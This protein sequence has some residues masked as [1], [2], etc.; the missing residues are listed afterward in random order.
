MRN[1][2]YRIL[3]IFVTTLSLLF[4][5]AEHVFPQGKGMS[6]ASTVPP[7]SM[8]SD[9]DARLALARI[10]SYH[11]Q[12][13]DEAVN[14]YHTLLREYPFNTQIIGELSQVY[15]QQKKYRE[16]LELLTELLK[17]KPDDYTIKIA[18][19]KVY[20]VMKNY[21]K[22]LKLFNEIISQKVIDS[23]LYREIGN[24]YLYTGKHT[25]AID[26]YRKALSLNPE[27][28]RIQKQLALALSWN[29][30][31]VEAQK[32]LEILLQQQPEDR[33][34]LI[35][36]ARLY[37]RHNMIH[38]TIDLLM[39]LMQQ[40]PEDPHVLVEVAD[41]EAL[42]GH[43]KKCRIL[44]E[45]ALALN[46][47]DENIRMRYA[48]RMNMWGD[49]YRAERLYKDYL[50]HHPESVEVALK[51][52]RVYASSQRYEESEGLYQKLL[53][54]VKDPVDVLLG[55][56]QLKL[57]E[58]DFIASIG[59]ADSILGKDRLHIE[60]LRVKGESLLYLKEY[61]RAHTVY[62]ALMNQ[63]KSRFSGLIGMGKL[64]RK[65]KK[66]E[67]AAIYFS[68]ALHM[69]PRNVE[70]QFYNTPID[71]VTS[72]RFIFQLMTRE[73]EELQRLYAWA[74][75]Y[76]QY[77]YFKGAILLL[78]KIL[79][80]DPEY[81]PAQILLAETYGAT[82]QYEHAI[83]MYK[84][85][86]AEFLESSKL[87][88]GLARVLGWSKQYRESIDLYKKIYALN[89]H[90]PVPQK[91]MAR[92]AM[93]GK[94]VPL[95][96]ATYEAM[97]TEPV[98]KKLMSELIRIRPSISDEG[99]T[100]YIAELQNKIR[101][102]SLYEGYEEFVNN[103]KQK[104][105]TLS[106]QEKSLLEE[107]K[108]RLL[109]DYRI[110]KSI[111]LEMQAKWHSWNKHF[112]QS[113]PFYEALI[114]FNP[115]NE[116]A[117]FDYAQA[118]CSLGI[119][120]KEGKT[121]EKLLTIDP[122]HNLARIALERQHIRSNPS[123]QSDYSYWMEDGRGELSQITRNRF[124]LTFD[125]PVSCRYR[126]SATGHKWLEYPKFD[127]KTYSAYGFT[128]GFNGVINPFIKSQASWTHK[129][130]SNREIK[131]RDTGFA[132]VWLN[133]KEYVH[134]G[135]GYERKDELYNTFGIRHGIQSD[136]WWVGFHSD[137][138]RTLELHGT[139]RIL[140]YNDSNRGYHHTLAL[141]Y[142]LTDHPRTFKITLSG[143][144]R[145][146]QHEN[147]YLY[148]GPNLVDIIHPYWTPKGYTGTSVTFQWYHD[149]SHLFF[150]G[151]ELR[152]YDIRVSLG[153]DS[154]NNP[155]VKLEGEWHHEF[156][157]R[158]SI[159]LKGMVHSSPKWDAQGIW[160]QL[161]YR[162]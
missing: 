55:L 63:D 40:H 64:L 132:S 87:L 75:L 11:T 83:N 97:L 68:K 15:I 113:L 26:Y 38:K 111:S 67:D 124:D 138:T 161:K 102:K 76:A 131:D 120:D 59:Y 88:I 1:K 60:A 24:L 107:V 104:T 35:E 22:A 62:T 82:N 69:K 84:K 46:P 106:Q 103:L 27:S 126:F 33:E 81:Y 25:Q 137:I 20:L 37:A 155:S 54:Y 80:S 147:L 152:F 10:L 9:F 110:Q 5:F 144:Y 112:T 108:V 101:K 72:D 114:V 48:D 156:G 95:G 128:I 86:N 17:R 73:K 149:Y 90:D 109:P 94:M 3:L 146:T 52:A 143:E 151:N 32:M 21:D 19:G 44:Y 77:G 57:L 118:Q 136:T 154:E 14:E 91:E 29:Q 133:A 117:Y 23:E 159:G 39:P 18:L 99:F 158:W 7:D 92:V 150:C 157:K 141:G 34:I 130:Y 53:L 28:Y 119:C 70:A 42:L 31:D 127:N 115:E 121:Y 148:S 66:Y 140:Q 134:L 50:S 61:E 162:F 45:K 160:V 105:W 98:D 142:A 79:E 36:L 58:K 16:A 2:D 125:F 85:L 4:L 123:I 47:Y 122:L 65:Q 153:T 71:E 145:D 139:A 116:E 135:V 13:L 8:I 93:W 56:A 49:F 129:Q 89:P 96:M 41:I 6:K 100:R 51:L 12:T 30:E 78:N 74:N 43:A